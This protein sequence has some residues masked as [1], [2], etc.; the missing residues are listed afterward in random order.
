MASSAAWETRG[1]E[2]VRT[3]SASVGLGI[4]EH[5][6]VPVAVTRQKALT[7]K[8]FL[9]QRPDGRPDPQV[10]AR[11]EREQAERRA[12]QREYARAGEPLNADLASVGYPVSSVWDL[13]NIHDDYPAALPVLVRHLTR[14]YPPVIRDGIARALAVGRAR[15]AWDLVY[16]QFMNE[17]ERTVK[18]GLAVALSAMVDRAHLPALLALLKDRR[19]GPSRLMLIRGVQRLRDPRGTAAIEELADDPDLHNQIEIIRHRK[20]TREARRR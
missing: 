6:W 19:H 8:E 18:D 5:L 2:V 10:R 15:F 9:A 11:L 17:Q 4:C 12:R 1:N 20:L 3:T 7:L 14:P 16:E 13:V